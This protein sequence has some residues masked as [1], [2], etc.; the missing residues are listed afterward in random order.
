[1]IHTIL[2][3]ILW[4]ELRYGLLVFMSVILI[5]AGLSALVFYKKQWEPA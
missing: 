2:S 3:L 5:N 4:N 1:M